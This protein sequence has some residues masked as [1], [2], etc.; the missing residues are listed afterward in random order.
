MSLSDLQVLLK[1][2]PHSYRKP[3]VHTNH[4]SASWPGSGGPGTPSRRGHNPAEAC[5]RLL[6]T[7][8]RLLKLCRLPKCPIMFLVVFFLHRSAWASEP[9]HRSHLERP[10]EGVTEG[11]AFG[12]HL[13]QRKTGPHS[14]PARHHEQRGTAAKAS[15]R[16]ILDF[17]ERRADQSGS[18]LGMSL[19]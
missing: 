16:H 10:S 6:N 3:S 2:S 17:P 4:T 9:R 18:N 11:F 8:L 1:Y 5:W 14:H 12:I 13:Q 15:E 19:C 7:L